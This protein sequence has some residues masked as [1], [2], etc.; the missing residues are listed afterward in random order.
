MQNSFNKT[1]KIFNAIYFLILVLFFLDNLHSFDIKNQWFKW[2]AYYGIL[3]G[4]PLILGWNLMVIK[5]KYQKIL[6]S[7][8]PTGILTMVLY[9]G[10][11]EILF[12]ATAWKTQSGYYDNDQYSFKKIEYQRQDVGALG[13]KK[14]WVEVTYITPLFMIIKEIPNDSEN[15]VERG[16]DENEANK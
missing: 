4:T 16:I 3:I 10:P 6:S 11:L 8:I 5:T 15:K 13:Y 14:R 7:I 12:S 1:T 9:F 2:F